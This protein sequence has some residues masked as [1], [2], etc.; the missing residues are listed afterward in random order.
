MKEAANR[1][2]LWHSAM[3]PLFGS[4]ENIDGDQDD[5]ILADVAV[6]MCRRDA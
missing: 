4:F 5:V 1:G 2:D 3:L 6:V